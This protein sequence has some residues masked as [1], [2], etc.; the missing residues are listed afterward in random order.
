MVDIYTPIFNVKNS[1]KL[2]YILRK[3]FSPISFHTEAIVTEA[4][5][6]ERGHSSRYTYEISPCY[7]RTIAFYL[8][9]L[10]NT[11]K[12]AKVGFNSDS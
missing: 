9:I 4:D 10:N 11:Y 7:C 5:M 8:I 1:T 6:G 2:K 12:V 3:Y